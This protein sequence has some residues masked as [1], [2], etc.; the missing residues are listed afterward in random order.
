MLS[1]WLQS[2]HGLSDWSGSFLIALRK[3]T[4]TCTVHAPPAHEEGLHGDED[5]CREAPTVFLTSPNISEGEGLRS[6]L[7]T[8]NSLSLVERLHWNREWCDV[9]REGVV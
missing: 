9:W 6:N 4:S 8:R 3:V 5:T 2:Q 7:S 1:P